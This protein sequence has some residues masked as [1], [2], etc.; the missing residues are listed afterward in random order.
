MWPGPSYNPPNADS[1]IPP[2]SRDLRLPDLVYSPASSFPQY[3]SP[4][5]PAY[6]TGHNPSRRAVPTIAAANTHYQRS[7]ATSQASLDRTIPNSRGTTQLP[8]AHVPTAPSYVPCDVLPETVE[9]TIKKK[10]KPRRKCADARQVEVLNRAYA[11]TAYPSAE[12]L[13]QLATDLNM[14]YQRVKNWLLHTFVYT[15]SIFF[16]NYRLFSQVPEQ[17]AVDPRQTKSCQCS[18]QPGCCNSPCRHLA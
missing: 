6:A 10:R 12:E 16:L 3:H 9:R 14:S 15:P 17:K 1:Q 18:N 11:H 2:T 5:S 13:E 8:Y 4:P 7:M